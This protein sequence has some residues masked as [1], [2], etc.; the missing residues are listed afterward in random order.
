MKF[1]HI[2]WAI[3]VSVHICAHDYELLTPVDTVCQEPQ[4]ESVCDGMVYIWTK[5]DVLRA[6]TTYEQDRQEFSWLIVA[7]IM[8][9]AN[10]AIKLLQRSDSLSLEQKD[11]L[12]ALTDHLKT[13][14]DDA[15]AASD[16][17]S[18]MCTQN[19][20]GLLQYMAE[21]TNT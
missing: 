12:H 10:N 3:G 7:D 17:I 5:C 15:F 16:N 18:I 14:Y 13:A 2:V 6:I 11:H 9:V 1:I 4:Y 21:E 19:I 20:L 8:H